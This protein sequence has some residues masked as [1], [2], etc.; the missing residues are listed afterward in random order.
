MSTPSRDAGVRA[1]PAGLIVSCQARVGHPLRHPE[2]M[3]AMA[4]AAQLAG[5]VGIRAAGAEDITAI[6]GL[7]DLPIVGLT[8]RVRVDSP[9]IITATIEDAAEVAAAGAD[10]IAIDLTLRPR[11]ERLSDAA[12][13][14]AI[15]ERM[16][17][18]VLADTDSLAGARAAV[19]AGADGVATTLAGYTQGTVPEGPALGL[20]AELVDSLS[21]PVVGE[22]RFWR[23]EQVEEAFRLGAHAVVVG[24]AITDPVAIAERFVLASRSA[25]R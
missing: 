23:P 13:I 5:A 19:A 17:K 9:V 12:L 22:G 4:V 14:G 24:T 8:K 11:P 6:R 3:A 18:L 25:P 7:V 2:M 10:I 20:L 1:L 16:G 21:V 15:H